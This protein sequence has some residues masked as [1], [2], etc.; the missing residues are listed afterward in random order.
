MKTARALRR[1]LR[2]LVH[3]LAGLAEIMLRFPRLPQAQRDLRVQAWVREMVQHLAIDLR[4]AGPVPVTGPLLLVANHISW[5]DIVV[6]HAAHHCRFVSKA[7]VRHWPLIGAL[8][9]GAGTLYIQR[10]SRRDALRVVH[11]M[12]KAL[13]DG[14]ILAVFPEGT[15]GDGQALLPFHA[16]LL[17]AAIAAQAPVQPV[18]LRYVDGATGA[19]SQAM[20]Y[21]DDETLVGSLWRTLCATQVRADVVFGAAQTADGRDRR[22]WA[23]DLRDAIGSLRGP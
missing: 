7:D 9:T 20:S 5:L 21:V 23:R 2:V 15:T 11:H 13:Q 14:D 8:A 19:N 18:A 6:L 17:Q 1:A 3:I 16:N 4:I 22:T 12:A 10:D